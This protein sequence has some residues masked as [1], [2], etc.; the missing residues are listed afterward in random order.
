M[1]NDHRPVGLRGTWCNWLVA[2][3]G[4]LV[5]CAPTIRLM[6]SFMKLICH[7]VEPRYQITALE[8]ILFHAFHQVLSYEY[9]RSISLPAGLYE[10]CR[11]SNSITSMNPIYCCIPCVWSRWINCKNRYLNLDAKFPRLFFFAKFCFDLPSP[12]KYQYLNYFFSVPGHHKY[13]M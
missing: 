6:S 4:F 7:L 2:I 12:Y 1:E 9:Y 5:K 13:R 10:L 3:W 8:A 11:L